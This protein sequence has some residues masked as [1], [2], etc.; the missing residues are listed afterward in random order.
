NKAPVVRGARACTVCRAAKMKCVSAEDGTGKCQ[1]C[2]RQ[3]TVCVFEKHRRGRKPGSKLSEA[4]KM[5]RRLE[6]G[7][8]NA[9]L[10]NPKESYAADMRPIDTASSLTTLSGPSAPSQDASLSL[11]HSRAGY[12]YPP[13]NESHRSP[14]DIDEDDEDSNNAAIFPAKLIRGERR[15][16]LST[17]LNPTDSPTEHQPRFNNSYSSPESTSTSLPK[18]SLP[19][20]GLQDPVASGL[21]SEEDVSTL[22]DS[23][24]LRLNPFINLFDPSLHTPSYVRDKCPFLFT[25]MLMAACKFWKPH[26]FPKVKKLAHDFSVMAFAEQ[27]MRVEVVQAFS[28]LTYWKDP[29]DNRTW[30]YIGYACRMAVE[31]GLNKRVYPPPQHESRHQLLER[32]NRERT[33]LVIFVHDRSLSTQTGRQY[34]LADDQ[35]VIQSKNWHRENGPF[36][37]RPEDVIVAAFVELRRLVAETTDMFISKANAVSGADASGSGFMH[38]DVNYEAVLKNCN[39]KLTAWSEHWKAELDKANGQR[40]HISFISIFRLYVR[41][42]LNSFGIHESMLPGSTKQPSLQS[43]SACC[44]SAQDV[45]KIASLDFDQL[46]VLGYGQDTVTIM[47]AYCAVFLL[48]VSVSIMSASAC[49]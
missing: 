27:W 29:E 7:L 17:I 10:K 21:I 49:C 44:S 8:N 47:T 24:F 43:L 36:S 40:F 48:R 42:F 16:F 46:Q 25:T 37:V 2:Q 12:G 6:K 39:S 4:S 15:S 30:M 38:S 19:P 18:R 28:C 13:Q 41:V 1:R 31:L 26:V 32:R 14:M 33:Y 23:F 45:L 11:S 20:P 9:K 35:F 3:D 34:M 5:L 22:F